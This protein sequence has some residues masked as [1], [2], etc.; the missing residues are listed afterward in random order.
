MWYCLVKKN[1]LLDSK[2]IGKYDILSVMTE[3]TQKSG[4]SLYLFFILLL[5]AV[6]YTKL[7]SRKHFFYNKTFRTTKHRSWSVYLSRNN[8]MEICS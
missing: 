7:E 3:V 6:F 8:T 1:V 2:E 4:T 5:R